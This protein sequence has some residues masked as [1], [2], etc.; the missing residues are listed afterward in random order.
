MAN[1]TG[2]LSF[3]LNYNQAATGLPVTGNGTA[4]AIGPSISK[5]FL[6]SASG[7]AAD[8]YDTAYYGLLS[9]TGTTP[10]ALDL[11]ALTDIYGN[12]ISF[13]HVVEI[14]VFPVG[15]ADGDT[16]TLGY[17]GTTAGAW[18]AL[19]SNPGT[20]TLYA[21]PTAKKNSPMFVATAPNATA[22]A[23]TASTNHLLEFTPSAT[24]TVMVMI[25]GRST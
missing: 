18:T 9:L 4:P 21:A 22:W 24:M 20:I 15:V 10:Q 16:L 6:C 11:K 1:V 5:Q 14:A 23:V 3:T 13:A 17:S 19:L 25:L 8:Q 2:S 7:T 12:A